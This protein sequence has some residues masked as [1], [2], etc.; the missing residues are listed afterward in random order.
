VIHVF[1]YY[2]VLLAMPGRYSPTFIGT[3]LRLELF[4]RGVAWKSIPSSYPVRHDYKTHNL[5]NH[6]NP[7]HK[8]ALVLSDT[9]IGHDLT[10]HAHSIENKDDQRNQRETIVKKSSTINTSKVKDLQYLA[11][12]VRLGE[13]KIIAI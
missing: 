13:S 10:N 11:R 7:P 1:L 2:R 6:A 3:Q 9:I 5:T 4:P 12:I 8:P